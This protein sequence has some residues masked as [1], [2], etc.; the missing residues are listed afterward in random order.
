M[1][2]VIRKQLWYETNNE[3]LSQESK[4]KINCKCGCE[5]VKG[6]LRIHLKSKK[7]LK[8]MDEQLTL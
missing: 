4:E 3:R 2:N 8:S 5:I 7:H 1:E 6:S